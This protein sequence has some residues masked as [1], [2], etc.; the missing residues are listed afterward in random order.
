MMKRS[1][2]TT[3]HITTV[4]TERTQAVLQLLDS[5]RDKGASLTILGEGL[6]FVGYS[7]KFVLLQEYLTT[8]HDEDLLLFIDGYDTLLL[9]SPEYIVEQFLKMKAP[10]VVSAD[11]YCYPD[12]SL[13]D[14][15]LASRTPFIYLNSGCYIGEVQALREF[16]ATISPIDP[17]AND[18]H[19]M[20]L[21]M[22]QNRWKIV[23]DTHC[24]LFLS[25]FECTSSD[26]ILDRT[27][28]CVSYQNSTTPAVIHGCRKS[29]W[30]QFLYDTLFKQEESSLLPDTHTV[31]L[32]ILARDNAALLPRFL[33]QIDQLDY[34][35]KNITLFIRACNS[36][37]ET[38]EILHAWKK[39]RAHLYREV[40]LD[41]T[42]LPHLAPSLPSP[43][44]FKIPKELRQESLQMALKAR[45]DYFFNVDCDNFI[46]PST[47]KLL[48]SKMKPLIAPL[49]KNFPPSGD[50]SSNFFAAVTEHGTFQDHP[51]Y[52]DIL[53]GKKRGTFRVPLVLGSYLIRQDALQGLT[54]VDD[55]YDP[56]YIVFARS[57]REQGVEQYVCNEQDF[58]S[59]IHLTSY[60]TIEEAAL[61]DTF[62]QDV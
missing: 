55:T 45:C 22:L 6:P 58:G 9:Q 48:V 3:L 34:N 16:L 54:Y 32:S 37:D 25:T 51:D 20:M 41:T 10:F 49:L 33:K 38:N 19:L 56:E 43:Q 39:K 13:S 50:L 57:V 47:L 27:N 35:K 23:L 21:Y 4:A 53:Q 26:I 29:L 62:L 7:Q 8:L 52:L 60:P 17:Q 44:R 12:E 40:I 61:L 15:H 36:S 18:Q 1:H 46:A 31:F 11:R 5:C 2:S 59:M 14:L 28:T 42:D 30:Y 24:E